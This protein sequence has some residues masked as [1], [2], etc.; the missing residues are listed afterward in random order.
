MQDDYIRAKRLGARTSR[1]DLISGN[2]LPALDTILKNEML[3]EVKL[4]LV[5]IPIE[6]IV[7]TKTASRQNA[8]ASDFMPI[9]EADTEFAMKWSNLYDSAI[10]EG[11]REQIIVY[12]Y[13]RKF[14]V[15][16]GNKRVSVSRFLG[17]EEILANVTRI[18]PKKDGSR[19]SQLYYEFV[20]FYDVCPLYDIEFSKPGDYERLANLIGMDLHHVWSKETVQDLRFAYNTFAKIF[21]EKGG[22]KLHM[23]AGDAF[24]PYLDVYGTSSLLHEATS[25]LEKQV[26]KVWNEILLAS[27]DDSIDLVETPEEAPKESSNLISQLLATTQTRVYTKDDPLRVAFIYS[28]NAEH[29]S[30]IYGHELGRLDLE[31]RFNGA[32]DTL[33]FDNCSTDEEVRHAIDGAVADQD[34]IIITVSPTMMAETLKSAIHYPDVQFLNC[35]INL[36]HNA[37]QTYY[38]RMYEAKFLMGVL[39]GTLADN[40]K[41]GYRADYPNYGALA[42]INAFAIGAALADPQAKVYLS[43]SS[44]DLNGWQETFDKEDIRIIS[45]PNFIQPDQ[46]SR[47]YG[48]YMVND[49]KTITNLAA[50]MIN[51]GNYYDRMLR[52]IVEGIAPSKFPMKKGQAV[53]YWWGMSSGMVDVILGNKVSYYSR[54][55]VSRLKDAVKTGRLNPFDGE[56]HSQSGV[57]KE[58]GSPRLSNREIIT[59]NYLNDNVIGT[60]PAFEDLTEA[61]KEA[62]NV[63]GILDDVNGSTA[64]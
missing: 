15:Q 30:W 46:A 43:W 51:W 26:S 38:I 3:Q 52:P 40:H 32:V 13:M 57:V 35:S 36:S 61:G 50:P 44:V 22:E 24:L 41:I 12:E 18:M 21:R 10:E 42:D 2:S 62:V 23:T 53:N 54:K 47:E 5:E 7:G 29:S 39:A 55:L 59:M 17:I 16:E 14:Y 56:L 64:T 37:V 49:D 33:M 27:N 28:K 11:I 60:I 9:L 58:I 48:L 34:Q 63:S 20:D 4:G 45:G 1:R 31:S 8:F 25:L 6:T 19:E